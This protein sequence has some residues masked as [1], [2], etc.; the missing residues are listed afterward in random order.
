MLV[1]PLLD[2]R[3]SGA[4]IYPRL[5]REE[6]RTLAA[7][8]AD[9]APADLRAHSALS[10]PAAAPAPT[11][12][13]PADPQQISLVRD[14]VRAAADASGF[15]APLPR[16][17]EQGF[18]RPC[19]TAI[20]AVMQIVPADAASEEVWTFLSTVVLPEIGPWRFPER[21]EE[22]IL[23]RPRNVLRRLWWRA[24]SLGPDLTWSPAPCTP[25]GEDEFV[26]IMERPSLGGNPRT[27]RAVR[28]ALW[29][30]E[31]AGL[32]AARSEV[33]RELTRRLRAVVPHVCVDA[34]TQPELDS[35]LDEL[36]TAAVR[37]LMKR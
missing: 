33:A 28:D 4:L 7:R 31:R 9:V 37:A 26:G 24:W 12:G 10:H 2:L 34:L 3:A 30:I 32:T 23:G 17:G 15:P 5:P 1:S 13:T 19:G 6:G 29:R 8:T 14:T 22:R 18:D 35:L 36:G 27:A 11:G 25:L 16:G 20:F 21:A